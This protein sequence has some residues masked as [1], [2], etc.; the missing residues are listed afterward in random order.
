[1]TEPHAVLNAQT[2]E[3]AAALLLSC[4]GSTRWV[5][6]MLE[7]RPFASLEALHAAADDAWARMTRVDHL[8]AFGRHPRIGETRPAGGGPETTAKWSREEQSRASVADADTQRALRAANAAYE[9]RF[10]FVFLVCATGKTAQEI[11][12]NLESRMHAHPEAELRVA[13]AEQAKITHLRLD[14]LRLEKNAR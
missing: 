1:M 6:K 14:K 2:R 4:C 8:E 12:R 11:L 3:E 7:R 9:E 5:E 13:A 10:G